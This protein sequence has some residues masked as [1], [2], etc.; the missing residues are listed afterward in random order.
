MKFCFFNL[1]KTKTPVMKRA[2]GPTARGG[3]ISTKQK[4]SR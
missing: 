1:D 3:A 4:L 2:Q